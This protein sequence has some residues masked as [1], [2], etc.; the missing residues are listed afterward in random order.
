MGCASGDVSHLA[1]DHRHESREHGKIGG[2]F[3]FRGWAVTVLA[4]IRRVVVPLAMGQ[5]EVPGMCGHWTRRHCQRMCAEG[6]GPWLYKSLSDPVKAGLKPGLLDEFRNEYKRSALTYL[7]REAALRKL[8]AAFHSR[9]IPAILLNGCYLAGFVYDDPA[10]RPMCDVDLLVQEEQFAYAGHE[11]ERLLYRPMFSTNGHQ[12]PLSKLPTV[13][14]AS[15]PVPELIDLHRCI[16]SMDYYRFPANALW[17]DT[18][19]KELYGC[20]VLCLSAEFNF[21]HIGLH[22]FDHQSSLRDWVDLA[23]MVRTMNLDWDRL[24]WLARSSGSVRPLFWVFKE[25]GR[26]WGIRL[27]TGFSAA[28]DSYVPDWWEDRVI[29]HRFRYVWRLAARISRLNGWGERFRYIAE[30]VL[31]PRDETGRRP[32]SRYASYVISKISLFRQLWRRT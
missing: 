15:Y 21:I 24:M 7:Y 27:P 11:L 12:D 3:K 14:R 9:G 16:Q 19:E 22:V 30:K 1:T 23:T 25:L 6:L 17:G 26:N 31:P 13:Y 28:L 8:F 5:P 4:D 18:E 10:P 2:K 29:R 20:K 32:V